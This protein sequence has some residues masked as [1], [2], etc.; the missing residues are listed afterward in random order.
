MIDA[1]YSDRR[2][3]T[4]RQVIELGPLTEQRHVVSPM[5]AVGHDGG[6]RERSKTSPETAPQN[7][8]LAL[9]I[10]ARA[11]CGAEA[12]DESSAFP[13]ASVCSCVI[14]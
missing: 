14:T 5:A 12:R 8:A 6:L 9:G 7:A 11:P 13:T 4:L 3:K 1:S 10:P 2:R